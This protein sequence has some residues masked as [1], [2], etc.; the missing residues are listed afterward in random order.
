M[1]LFGMC[2]SYSEVMDK[3]NGVEWGF[4]AVQAYQE[5]HGKLKFSLSELP[6]G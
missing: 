4:E 6:F 1:A 5:E 2:Y 3:L